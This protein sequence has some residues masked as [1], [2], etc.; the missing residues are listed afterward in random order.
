[1]TALPRSMSWLAPIWVSQHPWWETLCQ[2]SQDRHTLTI[3]LLRAAG[4]SGFPPVRRK[5]QCCVARPLDEVGGSARGDPPLSRGAG[6]MWGSQRPHW[7]SSPQATP[8]QVYRGTTAKL[9]LLMAP[10]V[11]NSSAQSMASTA[12]SATSLFVV[13]EDR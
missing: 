10:G 6:D 4:E 11:W 1:M 7:D 12:A 9:R 3:S 13:L 5:K 2:P 8:S